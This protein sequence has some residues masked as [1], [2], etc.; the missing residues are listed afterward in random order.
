MATLKEIAARC[1]CSVAAVSKALNGMPDISEAT[2]RR[3]RQA[4]EELGY[5]PNSAARTLRTNHSNVIGLLL[6]IRDKQVWYHEYFASIAAGIQEA[7]ELKGYDLA[8]VTSTA[9]GDQ[10]HFLSYCQYRGYDGVIVMCDASDK[11]VVEDLLNSE[12]PLVTI[13]RAFPTRSAVLSDNVRGMQDLVSYIHGMGH[14]RIAFIHG[15]ESTVTQV[16]INAFLDAC[17]EKGIVVPP[18]YVRAS[19]YRDPAASMAVT[20]EL[21][22]LPERPTCIIYPDDRAY[23]GGMNAILD[24]GLRIPEDVSAAGYDGIP[25]AELLRP[26]LTTIRQEGETLGRHA[27]E[28]ILE[29]IRR[30]RSFKPRHVTVPGS[31]I[32]G[33]TVA[34]I[35]SR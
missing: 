9:C 15:D 35:R 4:A 22:A 20:R 27:G 31:L 28:M 23:T 10:E 29:A 5:V 17:R 14:T 3:V 1:G 13:D 25:M 8:P 18:E 2:A 6:F 7:I 19:F 33:G 11:P 32:P 30:P 12:L 26:P 16:R 34:D 24:A 21:L